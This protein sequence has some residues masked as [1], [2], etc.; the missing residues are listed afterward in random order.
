YMS[1][2]SLVLIVITSIV[3]NIYLR[4]Q[5]DLDLFTN[6][7]TLLIFIF[8]AVFLSFLIFIILLIVYL[9]AYVRSRMD[10]APSLSYVFIF[11]ACVGMFI[12]VFG[13]W[14]Y[15]LGEKLA[16]TSELKNAGKYLAESDDS[17]EISVAFPGSEKD[18]IKCRGKM[19][20]GYDNRFFVQNK[21]D[22]TRLDWIELQALD[23]KNNVIKIIE[24]NQEVLE[25]NQ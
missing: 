25:S 7:G 2:I 22:D 19:N 23:D 15:P 16:Y 10:N 18:C 6:I 20:V 8:T 21:F 1:V 4:F 9:V 12:F 3:I 11:P 14:V 24:S 5:Y 17:N 13:M